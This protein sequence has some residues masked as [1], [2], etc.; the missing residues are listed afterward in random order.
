MEKLLK[1]YESLKDIKYGWYDKNKNLHD[2]LYE[3]YF[4]LYSM[5]SPEEL[6]KNR[7]GVCWETVELS[8][9]ILEKEGYDCTSYFAI[10]N[11]TG[12][13]CHT[14]LVVK[15]N[16]K[17]YWFEVSFSNN[18]GVHEYDNLNDIFKDMINYFDIIVRD[19][20]EYNKENIQIFEY[21]NPGPGTTCLNFYLNGFKGKRVF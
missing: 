19:K 21:T 11:E 5:Q 1:I 8:R 7:I 6:E 20:K 4:E 17:Y 16:E 13:H 3:G 9:K 18:K 14:F 2:K 15:K 12:F 10:L